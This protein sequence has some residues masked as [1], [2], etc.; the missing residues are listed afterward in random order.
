MTT[1]SER[2]SVRLRVLM[3]PLHGARYDQILALAQATERAGFDAFFRSDHLLGV[4][5]DD[6]EHRPTDCWTTLAG[7]ARDT[8]RVRLGSLVTAATFRHP[9][10]LA[11]TAAAVDEMSGGRIELG[12]GAGWYEREHA[13]FGIEFPPVGTR[14]DRLQEQLE[15]ITGLWRTE[16]GVG[17]GFSYSGQ[18]YQVVAN[19]TPPR[20]TQSPHPPIIIGGSGPRR[21]PA[22]AAR[23]AAEFNTANW[24]DVAGRFEVFARACEQIGRD[25]HEARRS[26]LVQVAC[27]RS[28]GEIEH[29]MSAISSERLRAGALAGSPDEIAAR[30]REVIEIGADTVYLHIFNVDDLEHIALLG[31]EVL[32]HLVTA[33]EPVA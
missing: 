20:V 8:Q 6:L 23:F 17:A 29:R 1:P 9:G 13:G 19:R 24:G 11:T 18:H 27:G 32:P 3:E 25:P 26:V 12:I 4:N 33:P 30:L 5:P 22:L 28:A 10:I 2:H 16:P 31:E 7:L 21:T 14:F 15:I